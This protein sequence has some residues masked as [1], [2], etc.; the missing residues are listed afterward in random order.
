MIA[1]SNFGHDAA[2]FF[3]LGDLGRH[4][5]CEKLRAGVAIAI[6]QDGES[7]FVA[8]GL[9][10]KNG[11]GVGGTRSVASVSKLSDDTEV[12]PPNYFLITSPLGTFCWA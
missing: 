9:K 5:A 2:E 8:R 7:R 6:A 12:V 4:F 11:H 10:G 3:V 1:L